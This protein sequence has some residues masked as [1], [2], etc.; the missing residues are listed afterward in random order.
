[1]LKII[2]KFKI[3]IPLLG[4]C[5]GHQ[6]LA[7]SF[8]AKIEKM[9]QVMHGKTDDILVIK[10]NKIFQNFPKNFIATRYHSLEVTQKNLP[11]NI[12]VLA[13]SKNK[14]IMALK[15]KKYNIYGVQFHPESIASQQGDTLFKN[16]I[17][18]CQ[19]R[20]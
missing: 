20:K 10:K 5:L 19:K 2:E 16:F 15:I 14:T 1:M 17:K 8:G 3:K 11:K 4:I 7:L 6:A 13:I 9:K 18:L 12:E